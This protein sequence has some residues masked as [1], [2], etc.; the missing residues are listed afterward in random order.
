M[1]VR[2]RA[3][4]RSAL[5]SPASMLAVELLSTHPDGQTAL[6]VVQLCRRR[7]TANC[8]ASRSTFAAYGE[9]ESPTDLW[10]FQVGLNDVSIPHVDLLL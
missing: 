10:M 3:R 9:T 2:A 4:K 8:V 5:N 7:P 6:A 1:D